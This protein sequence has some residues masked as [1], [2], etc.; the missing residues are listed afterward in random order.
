MKLFEEIYEDY[1]R[2][3]YRF[4]LGLT[5]EPELAEELTQE[6]FFKALKASTSFWGDAKMTTWLFQIAKNCYHDY[7]RAEK[8]RSKVRE[9]YQYHQDEK[10]PEQKDQERLHHILQILETLTEPYHSVFRLRVLEGKS[11]GELAEHFGK[12]EAWARVTYF[13]AKEQNRSYYEEEMRG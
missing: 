13:R 11:H 12:S 6:M 7:L 8:R 9:E 1:A 5:Q 4:L 2:D 10:V 3:V